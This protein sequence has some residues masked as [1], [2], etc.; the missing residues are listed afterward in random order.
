MNLEKVKK[1]GKAEA[2]L[3]FPLLLACVYSLGVESGVNAERYRFLKML[4]ET[5]NET[6]KENAK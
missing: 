5:R 4:I 3:V 2:A 1:I 6:S